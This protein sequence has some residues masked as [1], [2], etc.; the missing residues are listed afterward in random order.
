MLGDDL[1]QRLVL[2]I[3][4]PDTGKV[5]AVVEVQHRPGFV[6]HR[7]DQAPAFIVLVH[8]LVVSVRVV[9]VGVVQPQVV[10][11]DVQVIG[12]PRLGKAFAP[13]FCGK[14]LR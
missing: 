7:I 14:Q 1:F 6:P 4:T 5:A 9:L 12:D 2:Y 11:F 8:H 3:N 10:V 13:G